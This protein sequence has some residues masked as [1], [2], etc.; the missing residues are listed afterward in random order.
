MNVVLH[1]HILKETKKKKE[2]HRHR[3]AY[4]CYSLIGFTFV[5][6]FPF[7]ITSEFEIEIERKRSDCN[8]SVYFTVDFFMEKETN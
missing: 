5:C 2:T 1:E 7:L 8:H 3:Y 4:V 6:K